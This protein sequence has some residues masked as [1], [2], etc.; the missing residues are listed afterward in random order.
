MLHI[1]SLW[2]PPLLR[3]I[4]ETLARKNPDSPAISSG[5]FVNTLPA[6]VHSFS[7]QCKIP[8]FDLCTPLDFDKTPPLH[9]RLTIFEFFSCARIFSLVYFSEINL[10]VAK[11]SIVLHN[12][13][14]IIVMYW[15]NFHHF[16]M[17]QFFMNSSCNQ[18]INQYQIMHLDMYL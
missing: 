3:I 18:S 7:Q 1:L 10:Y 6:Y 5:C 9:P 15:Q 2:L 12:F 11:T 17:F 16:N 4:V 13:I 14:F 8:Y